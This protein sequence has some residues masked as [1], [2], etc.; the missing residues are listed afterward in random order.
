[1]AEVNGDFPVPSFADGTGSVSAGL[2]LLVERSIHEAR[3]TEPDASTQ[4]TIIFGG[5][6]RVFNGVPAQ[7][8][9]EIIRIA[10]AG[11]QTKNVTGINPA[12]NRALSFSTV[13]DLPIAR[14]R[15]LQRFLEKRRDRSTKPDG[16]MILPSQLTI[17][18]GGSFSVFDG[19]PAEKVQEI[20]HI[21][22]AAKATETIN[23]TSINP[24][25]KRAISFS[26]AST[27][28]CVST[29]DV[30]IARR[31][32]LQRFFEKR[33]HRFVHTKPYS[34]TTSEADK[35]ETSPIVT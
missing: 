16:S 30:P 20:L 3:S 21:A 10:F 15:S 31:R 2:D 11:K 29:A 8:V 1:M 4:L 13:A 24:A 23:L 25:L 18:F 9:Q 34:A 32:S 26:N 28:A 6:C 17:I 33:R 27:V 19:I 14:R 22:A 5:S 35:N 7:K 12:L